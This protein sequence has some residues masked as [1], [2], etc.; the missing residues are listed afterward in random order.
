MGVSKLLKS[1]FLPI[2]KNFKFGEFHITKLSES[3]FLTNLKGRI[4]K[5]T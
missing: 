3:S 2:A 1:Q 5:K 4:P